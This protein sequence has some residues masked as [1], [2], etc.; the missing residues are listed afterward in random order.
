MFRKR[1]KSA[2]KEA[3][4]NI[5]REVAAIFE[6]EDFPEKTEPTENSNPKANSQESLYPP[7]SPAPSSRKSR[8][9]KSRD[10]SKSRESSKER[11]SSYDEHEQGGF[12]DDLGKDDNF[13]STVMDPMGR[14]IIDLVAQLKAVSKKAKIPFNKNTEDLCQEYV[15]H[16]G[17]LNNT[18]ENT[19]NKRVLEELGT[20]IAKIKRER[21]KEDDENIYDQTE[22]L[23]PPVNFAKYPVLTGSPRKLAEANTQF[24]TKHKFNGVTLPGIIEWLTNMNE[25]QEMIHV[26]EPEFKK[27]LLRCSTGAPYDEIS[28]M[29]E[30]ERSLDE[31]YEQLISQYDKRKKPEIAKYEL[32]IYEPPIDAT[33]AIVQTEIMKLGQRA[34]L[35]FT[36]AVRSVAYSHDCIQALIKALPKESQAKAQDKFQELM[37]K[38]RRDIK[39]HEFCLA[40]K[41][42]SSSIDKAYKEERYL[43]IAKSKANRPPTH[44]YQNT[45]QRQANRRPAGVRAIDLNN[46]HNTNMLPQENWRQQTY[47]ERKVNAVDS[48]QPRRPYFQQNNNYRGRNNYNSNSNFTRLGNRFNNYDRRNNN[49]N[50]NYNNNRNKTDD[51]FKGRH[52]CSLCGKN[53][54]QASQGC[55]QMRNDDG[56]LV[57]LPPS[58]GNCS[59]CEKENN[60][61]LYHPEQYCFNRPIMKKM[62]EEG[63]FRYPTPQERLEMQR[64]ISDTTEYQKADANL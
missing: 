63:K 9:S 40:M 41:R 21:E 61:I 60:K 17:D 56:K 31:M 7:E 44:N 51:K 19:V 28:A 16:L 33:F 37:I 5:L 22:T 34:C 26:S 43:R 48:N 6:D 4:P 47:T 53:S 30:G 25:A 58:T 12:I 54:H 23:N 45:F 35:L 3:E 11:Y 49:Y 55:F 13:R 32:E 20:E 50:S 8:R 62:L 2:S 52:H 64:Y 36:K 15:E 39:Y 14:I 10:R 46:E 1:D 27:Y 29:K 42:Y 18:I 38:K 59:I 24:P 57:F